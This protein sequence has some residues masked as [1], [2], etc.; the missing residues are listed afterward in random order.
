[1]FLSDLVIFT[2]A[3]FMKLNPDECLLS[4]GYMV[5][6]HTE[7]KS[8]FLLAQTQ[9]VSLVFCHTWIRGKAMLSDYPE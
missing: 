9:R 1:M 6:R 3:K 8:G 5:L 4:V 7:F 2:V